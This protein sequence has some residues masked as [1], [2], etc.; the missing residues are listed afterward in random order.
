MAQAPRR[1]LG[2]LG[3]EIRSEKL[4]ALRETASRPDYMW[5]R[6]THIPQVAS[7]LIRPTV[8]P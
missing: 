4:R 5:G 6:G 7:R 2:V 8:G 3:W 1:P